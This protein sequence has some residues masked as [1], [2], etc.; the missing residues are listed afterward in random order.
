MSTDLLVVMG[1]K[2]ECCQNNINQIEELESSQ[3]HDRAQIEK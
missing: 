1:S 3:S 2:Y